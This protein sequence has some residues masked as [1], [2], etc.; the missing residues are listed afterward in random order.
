MAQ[1]SNKK[2]K[3]ASH[4]KIKYY[5]LSEQ[6]S[7]SE[8]GDF[9]DE[10]SIREAE[11]DEFKKEGAKH[12][13][14]NAAKKLK[15]AQEVAKMKAYKKSQMA[16]GLYRNADGSKVFADSLAPVDG[17]NSYNQV[18]PPAKQLG[19][20]TD[21]KNQGEAEA[22]A[23]EVDQSKKDSEKF[24]TDKKAREAAEEA[25]KKRLEKLASRNPYDGL[26]HQGDG[27]RWDAESDAAVAGV[28]NYHQTGTRSKHHEPKIRPWRLGEIGE[29][30]DVGSAMDR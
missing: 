19:G 13:K 1:T 5:G 27:S 29:N 14:E 26:I 16:D 11:M 10:A 8:I 18:E 23:Q 30:E 22:E 6:R 20:D 3:K 21:T 9:E 4:P 15:Y 2:I 24:Q 7:E 28:N 12:D 17:V 25:E